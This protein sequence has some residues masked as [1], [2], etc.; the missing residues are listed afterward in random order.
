ML[1]GVKTGKR[2]RSKKTTEGSAGEPSN[3][4]SSS[5]AKKSSPATT[6][7]DNLSAAEEIR[8]LLAGGSSLSSSLSSKKAGNETALERLEQSGRIAS[9]SSASKED[10]NVLVLPTGPA[11]AVSLQKEDF[12]GGSRKG[13]VRTAEKQLASSTGTDMTIAQMVAEERAEGRSMDE[14]YARNVARLGSRFRNSEFVV[15]GSSA[16][17]DEDDMGTV[18]T[19]LFQ[20][21]SQES[22]LTA[23]AAAQ[24]RQSRA[25]AQH[26]KHSSITSKCWW[27]MESG[28]SFSK[29][30]LLSLGDHVSLVL[31]PPHLAL[32]K[33][34]CYLVPLKHAESFVSCEDEVWDEVQ[35][36]RTSLRHMFRAQ[37]KGVLFCE[38]V[39][40]SKSLWQARMDVIPVPIRV[41]Q[42]AP[43][44]FK[45][46][47]TEQAEEW[48]THTK[49]IS[50]KEKGGVRY[51]IPKGFPY[52]NIE[53]LSGGFAQM[54][55]TASFP[56]D[57]GVDTIAGMMDMEPLSFNRKRK[58]SHD[59]ERKA[60][61]EF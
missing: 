42:D 57:F 8:R 41:E 48:G 44:F 34:H 5:I 50:T 35:R 15:G 36:F 21:K 45:S 3:N 7:G 61:I 31:A 33:N 11:S 52:F 14:T 27:W 9:S 10:P 30:M 24:K 47:L 16:G 12:R 51:S 6:Q 59:E 20:E 38:T 22:R 58:S 37:G 54:I 32:T 28:P 26:D 60:V 13:K 18:D 56:K 43:I 25:I 53:W 55:E 49:L 17:A 40:P 4:S 23:A 2:K 19:A 39:L 29:H 1:L 46:A